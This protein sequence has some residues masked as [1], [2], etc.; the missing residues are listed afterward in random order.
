[1]ADPWQVEFYEDDDESVPVRTYL[2]ALPDAEIKRFETRLLVLIEKG[3]GAGRPYVDKLED[4]LW[5][6]RFEG[7]PHN[8]RVLFCAVQGRKLILLHGFAKIGKPNDKVPESEKHIARGRR[9]RYLERE[10][11][12]QVEREKT[13]A[14]RRPRKNRR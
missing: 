8:T 5:E 13:G 10:R 3:L 6:L 12:K 14:Q 7:S 2:D 9:A 4:G 11:A 1:M